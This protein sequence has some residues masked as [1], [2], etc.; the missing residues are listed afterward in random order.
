MN[1]RHTLGVAPG[2]AFALAV[3]L[4]ACGPASPAP[5]GP[6]PAGSPASDPGL[7]PVG[8][9]ERARVL[10]VVDGD[11]I[12]I[13]RGQGSEALRYIGIDT[14]ETVRPDAPVEWMGVEAA[15]SNRTL[16]EGREVVLERDVSDADPFGR[17]LRY[18]WLEQGTGWLMV[19]LELVARGYASAVTYPPDL[20]WTDELRDAQ[21]AA[22]DA[23][24]GLWGTPP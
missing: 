13:D 10:R 15:E 6:S 1:R 21:A 7:A 2:V 11:T 19:N 23:G 22:R 4:A 17:L 18:V 12:R 16:V 9:V 24:V 20:R 3:A 5:S 14:P 8:A